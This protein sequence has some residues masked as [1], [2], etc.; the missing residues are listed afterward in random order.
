A[1]LKRA[2]S[3]TASGGGPGG[4]TGGGDG[5]PDPPTNPTDPTSLGDYDLGAAKPVSVGVD[6]NLANYSVTG[7]APLTTDGRLV[8]FT[9]TASNLVDNDTNNHDDVFVR[10]VD[11]WLRSVSVT[12]GSSPSI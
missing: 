3:G 12:S 6:G 7:Q 11:G 2:L 1:F 9:S 10:Q 4:N 5:Y 8:A